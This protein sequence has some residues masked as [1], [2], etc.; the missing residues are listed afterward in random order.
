MT[1][2]TNPLALEALDFAPAILALQERP[3]SPLPRTLLYTLLA[4]CACLSIWAA[5]G[6]L[7]IIAVAE[8]SSCRR[9][10]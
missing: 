7:D 10:T 2:T 5:I 4:L 9:P 8:G 6:K 3:P 1:N